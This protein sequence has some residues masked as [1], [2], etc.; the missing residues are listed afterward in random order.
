MGGKRA[1]DRA[2]YRAS[3]FRIACA[4]AQLTFAA[5]ARKRNEG[6]A[7]DVAKPADEVRE[8]VQRKHD[9]VVGVAS[10]S[11]ADAEEGYAKACHGHE[12]NRHPGLVAHGRVRGG[13]PYVVV[14]ARDRSAMYAAVFGFI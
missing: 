12:T 5:E 1:Q 2:A 4:C 11:H 6:G 10:V 8:P 9:L 14:P 3:S 13:A 7:G